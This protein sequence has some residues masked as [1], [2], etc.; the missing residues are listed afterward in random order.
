M[1]RSWSTPFVQSF[2]K[3]F[4]GMKV[5]YQKHPFTYF[6]KWDIVAD[7]YSRMTNLMRP[8]EVETGRY[9]IGKDGRW[10][11]KRYKTDRVWTTPLH[12]LSGFESGERARADICFMD[13][14]TVQF[15][16]TARFSKKNPT[17]LSSWRFSSGAGIA[18]IKNSEVQYARRKNS[19]TGRFSKTE[20]LKELER[21]LL[22]DITDLKEWD[23]SILLL[24][25]DHG[26]YTKNEIEATFSKRLNPYT[27]KF[28]YLSPKSGF[29]ITGHRKQKDI[30]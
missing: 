30:D 8:R 5:E 19:Q 18:V 17:S 7:I 6:N 3:A 12:V 22:K 27:M 1:K 2:E 26:L 15:A 23:K 20:N 4:S 28:Y 24:V 14:E 16:M 10:R 29:F 11:Q 21:E 25:D 13:L 9:T